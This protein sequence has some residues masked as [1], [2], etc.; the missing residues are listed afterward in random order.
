M[1]EKT[2]AVVL[3]RGGSTRFPK[4]NLA[5]LG[6]YNFVQRACCS[7]IQA[8]EITNICV[9]S[10]SDEILDSINALGYS[11]NITLIKR[12]DSISGEYSTIEQATRHA[13]ITMEK[14]KNYQYD[15][16]VSLQAACPIRPIDGI[17]M[18]IR[19]IKMEGTNGGFSVVQRSNWI[20]TLTRD[21]ELLNNWNPIK[22]PRSQDLTDIKYEEINSIQV[23][24]RKD[25]LD[26]KRWTSPV[27]LVV[28]PESCGW[29]IDYENQYNQ[30]R[31][32]YYPGMDNL[33]VEGVV[34]IAHIPRMELMSKR[35]VGPCRTNI[36]TDDYI[37]IVL[38]NG[39]QIDEIDPS[40][41]EILKKNSKFITVGTNSICC[42]NTLYKAGFYPNIH[43]IW[44]APEESD[45]ICKQREIQLHTLQGLT[46]KVNCQATGVE[47]YFPDQLVIQSQNL[48]GNIEEDGIY[49]KSNVADAS[50]NLLYRMGIRKVYLL[51]VELNDSRHLSIIGGLHRDGIW[52]QECCQNVAIEA[53]KYQDKL[54]NIVIRCGCKRSLLVKRE[55]FKYEVPEEFGA[56]K[57][58]DER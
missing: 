41:W 7:A 35:F 4:K 3:A 24:L 52:N 46:W 31:S 47:K 22:Y 11:H 21:R 58:E 2:L 1:R 38:G 49:L 39:P 15:Y 30:L 28:L 37:G 14:N 25:T 55:I 8:R 29:D 44:D 36:L 51:G 6:D 13:L 16:V 34:P 48:E 33:K 20:W 53:F 23:S 50:I 10:D 26:L 19:T 18:L 40:V 27:S 17:D 32:I 9:S 45:D 12:P 43:L 54:P 56:L 57:M 5:I 42:S